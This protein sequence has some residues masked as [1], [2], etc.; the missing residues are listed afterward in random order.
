V[1]R[2]QKVPFSHLHYD[3]ARAAN[4]RQCTWQPLAIPF[5]QADQIDVAPTV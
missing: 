5:D 1:K 4:A 3:I 2:G